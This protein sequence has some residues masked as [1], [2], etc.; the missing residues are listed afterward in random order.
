MNIFVAIYL[1]GCLFTL[2]LLVGDFLKRPHEISPLNR[3]LL[4]IL[5][6]VLSW[7]GAG[8]LFAMKD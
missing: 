4:F 5:F 7:F 8:Y 6:T 3:T 2:G 1:A